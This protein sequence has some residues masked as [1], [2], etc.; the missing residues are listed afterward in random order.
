MR[1]YAPVPSS[2]TIQT[3]QNSKIKKIIQKNSE[4]SKKQKGHTVRVC[5]RYMVCCESEVAAAAGVREAAAVVAVTAA[6]GASSAG[7]TVNMRD[8][9]GLSGEAV[10]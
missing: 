7:I 8:T 5:L 6:R 4:K 1:F 10:G 2:L 9:A 3:E